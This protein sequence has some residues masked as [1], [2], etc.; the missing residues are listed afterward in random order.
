MDMVSKP[1]LAGT[2][3]EK[4]GDVYCDFYKRYV[5]SCGDYIDMIELPGDDYA[6]NKSLIISP[7]MFREFIKPVVKRVINTIHDI[8]SD[9]KIMLHS[10]GAIEK[11]IPDLI[12]MGV[13][14]LH[15]LEP[16]EAVDQAAIKKKFSGQI[17]FLGGVNIKQSLS[18]S[19]EDVFKEVDRV[20][21]AFVPGDGYIFAPSNHLQA[22]IPPENV[23]LLF[24]AAQDR[25]MN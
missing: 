12:E 11:L 16:L 10:D 22:D 18:G 25:S 1:N 14:V 6:G 13:D 19:K 23:A 24:K 3:I 4:I 15:P 9:V 17:V 8:K 5:Q 2:L 7:G 20:I 21:K